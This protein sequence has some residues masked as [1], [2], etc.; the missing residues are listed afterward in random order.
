M[1]PFRG[2]H[3]NH[4]TPRTLDIDTC[5]KAMPQNN[6]SPKAVIEGPPLREFPI[7]LRQTSFK[8]LSES[9]YFLTENEAQQQGKHTA[10]FGEIEQR[11]VALTPKGRALYDQILARV[12]NQ[13]SPSPDGANAEEYYEILQKEFAA[14]P[15]HHEMLHEQGLAYYT[16][17]LKE[18]VSIPHEVKTFDQ[19]QEMGL[20][21]LYPIVYEDFCLS[22]LRVFFFP[23]LMIKRRL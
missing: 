14:L 21:N 18:G 4:L 2:P 20:L 7:L 1:Y 6:I 11:G 19:L 5:Q 17:S 15:D 16:Y 13:I 12:R 10:R 3:I 22:V 8:A 9:V 23:I